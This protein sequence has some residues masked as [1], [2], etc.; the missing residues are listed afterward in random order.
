MIAFA[1]IA[2][3]ISSLWVIGNIHTLATDDEGDL[4]FPL[5]SLAVAICFLITAAR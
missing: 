4:I 5:F 1:I 2:I 3:V